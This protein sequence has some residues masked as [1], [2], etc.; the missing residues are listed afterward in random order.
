MHLPCTID[1]S[2]FNQQMA[3]WRPNFPNARLCSKVRW[4]EIEEV[5]PYCPDCPNSPNSKIML[6]NWLRIHLSYFLCSQPRLNKVKNLAI[7]EV[8]IRGNWAMKR[9]ISSNFLDTYICKLHTVWP[10]K[11]VPRAHSELKAFLRRG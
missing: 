3:P 6:E 5:F 10:K 7:L 4:F 8:E 11:V 2:F 9:A 1:S